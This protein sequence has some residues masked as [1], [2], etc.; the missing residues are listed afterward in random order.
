MTLPLQSKQIPLPVTGSLLLA[1][2][3]GNRSKTNLTGYWGLTGYR[4]LLVTSTRY[5]EQGIGYWVL[6]IGYWVLFVGYWVLCTEY[7]CFLPVTA[8]PASHWLPGALPIA[9]RLT[10]PTLLDAYRRDNYK[11]PCYTQNFTLAANHRRIWKFNTTCV[12]SYRDAGYG[13][14]CNAKNDTRMK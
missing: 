9:A 4:W 14:S 3:G 1:A 12:T 10:V 13:R 6:S 11:H 7:C 5:W 2:P 8:H